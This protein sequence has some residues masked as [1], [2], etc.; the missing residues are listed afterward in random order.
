MGRGALD[1]AAFALLPVVFFIGFPG[2]TE[3]VLMG[4]FHGEAANITSAVYILVNMGCYALDFAA[5]ALLPVIFF[6]RSPGFAEI[7]GVRHK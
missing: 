4:D 5:F 3:I 2:F 1:F 7:V 6:I